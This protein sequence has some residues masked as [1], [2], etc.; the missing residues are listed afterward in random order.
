[1]SD[2]APEAVAMGCNQYHVCPLLDQ[3]NYFFI[4]KGQSFGKC[5]LQI[6]PGEWLI[7]TEVCIPATLTDVAVEGKVGLHQWWDILGAPLGLY[8][9]LAMLHSSFCFI[10]ASQTPTGPLMERPRP[11]YRQPHVV[12]GIQH[13]PEGLHCPLLH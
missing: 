1:M 4:P 5:V 8:L 2:N 3:G 13:C 6:L 12:Q 7:F 10:K 9:G 11:R